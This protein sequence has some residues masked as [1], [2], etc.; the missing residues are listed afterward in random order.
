VVKMRGGNHSKEIREYEITSHGVVIGER[1]AGYQR[2]ITGV[3]IAAE[4]KKTRP[5]PKKG[6]GA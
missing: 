4:T 6:Q 3:P 2:L 1:I 5:R